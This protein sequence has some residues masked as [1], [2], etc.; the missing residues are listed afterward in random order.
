MKKEVDKKII[1]RNFYF[2]ERDIWWC[3]LGL[4]IGVESNGKND[5][6]ERPVLILKV[7]NTDM[8]WCLSITSTI[9]KPP[10]YYKLNINDEFRSVVTTQFRTISSK[11]LLRKVGVV[12]E[13]DF[14]EI[15][16]IVISFIKK[17]NPRTGRGNLGGRSH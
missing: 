4:N 9:K 14:D 1:S 3:S 7:F 8:I 12:T 16:R 15:Q 11:R 10:F 13:S 2:H 5:S 6:F 17:R